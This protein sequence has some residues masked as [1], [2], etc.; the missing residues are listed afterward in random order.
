MPRPPAALA[1]LKSH[2]ALL[3]A[4][5]FASWGD[6][7]ALA[8][9]AALETVKRMIE[10]RQA[11]L[12]THIVQAR[13]LAAEAAERSVRNVPAEVGKDLGLA[14][15]LNGSRARHLVDLASECPDQAPQTFR[16]WVDGKVSEEQALTLFKHTSLLTPAGRSEAD[17][18]LAEDLP[19]LGLRELRKRLDGVVAQLEPELVAE[20]RKK[21]A[22]QRRAGFTYRPDGMM[23]LNALLPGIAGQA[24]ET[25]LS[26]YARSKRHG[27]DGHDEDE[28]TQDQLK[29]DLLTALVIGWARATKGV[30]DEFLKTHHI[31]CGGQP[32]HPCTQTPEDS[33]ETEAKTQ[34]DLDGSNTG[35]DNTDSNETGELCTPTVG[36]GDVE[37]VGDLFSQ[38]VPEDDGTS[39]SGQAVPVG[40]EYDPALGLLL[41][42]GVGV[43]VNLVMTDLSVFGITDQPAQIFGLG[44]YPA[45]MARELI[46]T[47]HTRH[48]ATL[49]RLYTEPVTG[50]LMR[51]EST[52]RTF[53]DGLGKMLALRDGH[54]R[55]PFCDAPIRHLDHIQPH[56]EGGPTSYSNGQGLCARHNLLKESDGAA[57]HPEPSTHP[58]AMPQVGSGHGARSHAEPPPNTSPIPNTD[59]SDNPTAEGSANVA[60]GAHPGRSVDVGQGT[61]VGNRRVEAEAAAGGDTASL[62]AGAII[63]VLSTDMKFTSPARAFPTETPMTVSEDHYWR[64]Y[65][66]GRGDQRQQLTDREHDLQRQEDTIFAAE[67]H[68]KQMAEALLGH[69]T[70][71]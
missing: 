9:L 43:H 10:A 41:P 12:T 54:C 46:H 48:A 58:E 30:P 38:L 23:N 69:S 40:M 15:K 11:L 16:L 62:G 5:A 22:E 4:E 39:A 66:E 2:V 29:A 44:P 21:A 61:D 64:G 35:T 32:G 14:R 59:T 17:D 52:A 65:R 56:A 71:S 53:P 20:R 3:N 51:M 49:R 7:E 18:T 63:T 50:A 33:A 1:E 57:T 47:A 8:G 24:M 67:D 28:R 34:R 36:F 31:G 25:I 27:K 6:G 19:N 37:T 55:Y 60:T 70:A 13:C 42:A 45:E 26:T 68:L